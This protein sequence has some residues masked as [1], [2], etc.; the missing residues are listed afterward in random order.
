VSYGRRI[1]VCGAT[2]RVRAGEIVALIGHNGCGKSTTLRAAC[3]LV[4]YRR[5]EIYAFGRLQIS[6]SPR[7]RARLPVGI[8]F[9]P[10]TNAVF[11]D[12]SVRD[13]L[14]VAATAATRDPLIADARKQA[15]IELF[16]EI[17]SHLDQRAGQ[18][19]GG[20]QRMVAIGLS[21]MAEPRLL[22]LDE[23]TQQLS[24]TAATRV[25]LAA[26]ALADSGVGVLIAENS[27][28]RVLQS[29]DRAY[30]MNAGQVRS[31]HVAAALA[32]E[33]PSRWW[34]LF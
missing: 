32:A 2:L 14:N 1:A 22:L 12:L 8:G 33:G 20:Q 23:P 24:P 30:V 9:V 15:F 26:R 16:P 29:A 18:L 34:R 25:L 19:S 7:S 11:D 31:E 4:P 27:V 3:G 13:N 10:A 5:G 28:A 21:M 6:P 17:E